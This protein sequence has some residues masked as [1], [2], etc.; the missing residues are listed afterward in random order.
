MPNWAL[1]ALNEHPFI[2]AD[3]VDLRTLL[4]W[5]KE[6]VL[7]SVNK[8]GKAIILHE[9]ILTGGIGGEIAA[10]ISEQCFHNL[11]APIVRSASLDTP[12]PMSLHLEWNFLPKE[13]F[14]K[15]LID[16]VAY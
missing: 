1:E 16:L 6:T 4:P 8:T 11:D 2:A 13:R 10:I 14:K 9:D 5:D 7:S 12:V 3:L 15:Q